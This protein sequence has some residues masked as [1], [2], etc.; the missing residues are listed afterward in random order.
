MPV[1]LAGAFGQRNPGDEA[2]LAAFVD[3]L[4]D[5][6]LVAT[7]SDPLAT[8]A[9][10][11]V[12]AV[13]SRD[14]WRVAR[15]VARAS[16]VVFAGGTVFKTL[17]PNSGRRPLALLHSA[18]GVAAGTQATGAPLAL[19][20]V[21]ATHLAGRRARALAAMVVRRAG[22]LVL[23]DEESA[24]LLASAGAP[25]PFRVGADPAW[26]AIA[27]PPADGWRGDAAIVALSSL[28]GGPALP[29]R[30][31][32]VL[33]PLQRAGLRVRL[34]PWQVLGTAAD[35]LALARA[36][37]RELPDRAEIV[38]PP[39]T[40]E[41][42]AD[43][44][45]GARVVVA[46]RFHALLAAAAAGVPAVAYAHEVKL[47]AL[48]RRLGQRVVGPAGDPDA[49][50]AE[51]AAAARDGLAPAP[52]A[53]IERERERAGEGMALLRLLLS[54]GHDDDPARV[55]GLELVPGGWIA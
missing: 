47:A 5:T 52:R 28:A 24:R 26:T 9:A 50:G 20:G 43:L 22:L 11:G 31:A 35:D 33:A 10:H 46:L 25:A 3:A 4:R 23:R 42:A 6:P 12:E 2:L 45:T 55:S 8:E 44:F 37:A 40:L 18:L 30:L 1:L 41:D 7:S 17:H 21:G 15:T 14:A 49:I 39:A 16:A 29:R 32:R 27:P 53:A 13:H 34:Q 19:V 51:I 48:A 38:P 54:G 36:L